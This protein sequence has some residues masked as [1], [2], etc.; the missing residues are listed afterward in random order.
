M[1]THGARRQVGSELPR[2]QVTQFLTG[3]A[4]IIHIYTRLGSR[5]NLRKFIKVILIS[6]AKYTLSKQEYVT[7]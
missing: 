7:L 2:E 3:S 4:V 6:A 1:A 5:T